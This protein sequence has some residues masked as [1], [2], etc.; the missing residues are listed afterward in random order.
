LVSMLD[1]AV[2]AARRALM[3]STGAEVPP[4]REEFL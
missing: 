3:G 1:G 2:G 4:T